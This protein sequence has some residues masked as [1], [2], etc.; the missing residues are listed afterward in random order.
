MRRSTCRLATLGYAAALLLGSATVLPAE[1]KLEVEQ[2]TTGPKQHFFGYIGHVRTIPWNA[3][4]R[5]ILGLQTGFQ[6]RMPTAS[7]EAEIILIDRQHNKQRRVIERTRAWNPQQGTM[8]YWN[9]LASE[10]QFFF[11]DRD[12]EGRVF[13]VLFDLAAAGGP[14]RIR[15]FRFQDTPVGNGGVNPRGNLLAAINYGRM[16]RLRP[17]TGYP[18]AFDWTRGVPH[19]RDD[20]IFLIDPASGEKRLLASFARLADELKSDRPDVEQQELFINHTLWNRD[21]D[22]LFFFAR[23]D[24]DDRQRRVNQPFLINA[25]GSGL[26]RMKQHIGG[27]PEWESGHRMI[28]AVD[29]RQVIY[30]TD[31]QEI[32]GQIGDTTVFPDPEGDIALSPDGNWLVNG[33]RRGTKNFYVFYRRSDGLT[34][35]S[36]A[37]DVTGWTSGNLRIDGAPCWNRDSNA[38]VLTALSDDA[39]R[40][41]QMFL[42]RIKE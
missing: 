5:F 38:V 14:K 12:A 19:P 1:L 27:H 15:E 35:R 36:L 30:D 20:G 26:T 31:R 32:V 23:A 37:F 18:E 34:L 16:A 4:G 41:R 10:S 21:G 28:G 9:P 24:F 22:R 2:L 6:D 42:I 25:D 40:T 29:G 3:S 17:V 33:Y 8:L 7:D 39:E 11:N 13:C